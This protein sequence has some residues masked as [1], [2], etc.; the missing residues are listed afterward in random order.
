MQKTCL[1]ILNLR[2]FG[3]LILILNRSLKTEDISE[4]LRV[5]MFCQYLRALCCVY[6]KNI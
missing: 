6:M 5:Q 3:L 4:N 1:E 2:L